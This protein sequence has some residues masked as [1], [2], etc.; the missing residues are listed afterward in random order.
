M[1]VLKRLK[2]LHEKADLEEG[3]L[4]ANAELIITLRNLAPALIEVVEAL[5]NLVS[6]CELPGDHCEVEQALLFAKQTLASFEKE[7]E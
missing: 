7:V 1:T 3:E 6:A 5:D 2:E 4:E